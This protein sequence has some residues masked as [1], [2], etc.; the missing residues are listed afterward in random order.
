MLIDHEI[1]T[2]PGHR[3]N[4]PLEHPQKRPNQRGDSRNVSK[5]SQIKVVNYTSEL[6]DSTKTPKL[7]PPPKSI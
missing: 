4:I 1:S 3:S 7:Q 2:P 6:I 5:S